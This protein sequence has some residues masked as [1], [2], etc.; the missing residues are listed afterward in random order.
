MKL[1]GNL[2]VYCVDGNIHFLLI[3]R[4]QME[5]T[6]FC[7]GLSLIGPSFASSLYIHQIPV[8]VDCQLGAQTRL[9]EKSLA[10]LFP[11]F[12]LPLCSQVAQ[13]MCSCKAHMLSPEGPCLFAPPY[14]INTFLTSW[15]LPQLH[16]CTCSHLCMC[17]HV[18]TCVHVWVP[19]H[20]K[21]EYVKT[22]GVSYHPALLSNLLVQ[23]WCVNTR[24]YLL[25]YMYSHMGRNTCMCVHM[26][27]HRGHNVKVRCLPQSFSTLFTEAE[28]LTGPRYWWI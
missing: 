3:W 13:G 9:E 12:P 6:M 17:I 25:A 23:V 4:G 7:S 11:S 14:W 16:L 10:F 18:H 27:E 22:K 19:A 21:H 26:C 8:P 24:M 2:D 5:V 28:L 20:T 15:S 1:K